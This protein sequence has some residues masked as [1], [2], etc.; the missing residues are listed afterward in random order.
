MQ[1]D[2]VIGVGEAAEAVL[3]ELNGRGGFDSVI[4]SLDRETLD[5]VTAAVAACIRRSVHTQAFAQGA[6]A[7]REAA[8]E[9]VKATQET[10][11]GGARALEPRYDGNRMGLAYAAGIRALPAPRP[12][13][14]PPA[15][16]PGGE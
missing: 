8:A 7:M 14:P 13:P 3:C 2:T 1:P 6:E 10:F 5:D 12:L 11:S 16:K 4:G 15:G 9:L